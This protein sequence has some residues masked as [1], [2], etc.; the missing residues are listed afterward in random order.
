[1][2]INKF[3]HCATDKGLPRSGLRY[4]RALVY[5]I[6][7]LYIAHIVAFEID[8]EVSVDGDLTL[9]K[10]ITRT[11]CNKKGYQSVGNTLCIQEQRS[12]SEVTMHTAIKQCGDQFAR[13]CTLQD[14]IYVCANGGTDLV[15]GG[16]WLGNYLGANSGGQNVWGTT[17]EQCSTT[18]YNF[19]GDATAQTETRHYRC[20]Y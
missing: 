3:L 9:G 20:C 1:M 16:M 12:D 11:T 2:E 4:C 17:N 10:S 18:D 8:K 5:I 14:L 13:V 15:K 19:D 6:V 7:A